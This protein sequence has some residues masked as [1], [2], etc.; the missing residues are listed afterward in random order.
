MD[1]IGD[2]YAQAYAWWRI[3]VRAALRAAAER[4]ADPLVRTALCAAAERSEAVRRE[5]ARFACFERATRDAVLR[6]SCLRT[7]DTARET[8][9]RRWVLRLCWPASKAYSALLRVLVL[10]LPLLGGRRSTPARLALER[11]MA[12]ACSG[13]LAPCS[14]RRILR[15][16]SRT[17]SPAW[18][19][20]ALPSRLSLGAFSTVLL[21]GIII[22]WLRR[23]WRD[24][25][26]IM[27]VAPAYQRAWE[28]I[29]SLRQVE[30]AHASMHQSFI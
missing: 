23:L 22:L 20:G 16:S 2:G 27:P 3:L 5:A 10:A 30:R 4:P 28:Q 17:N 11:P 14:P 24:G 1:T 21:S 29:G 12:I 7:R 15:I 25:L 6:G 9:G 18:V 8:R 26:A 19:V 13:D